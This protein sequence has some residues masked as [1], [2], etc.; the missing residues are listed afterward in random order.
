M[1]FVNC[2]EDVIRANAYATLEFRNT[3][4]LAFR[5]LPAIISEHVAGKRALDFGCGTGRSTRLLRRLGLQAMGIDISEDMLRLARTTDPDGEYR[6]VPGDNLNQFASGVFDL[7]L[8]AFTFDN[9]PQ[10]RKLKIF[11]DLRRLLARAGII[12][13]IVSSPEI[14]THEWASFSTKDFPENREARSGDVVRIVVTDHPD[15]RPVE[16]VVCADESYRNIYQQ[17][18][19]KVIQTF[20][21]LA[22]GDEDYSWVNETT[23]APWVIYVLSSAES[24]G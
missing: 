22:K 1:G 5:D 24:A 23:I 16:D 6:I 11:G 2:Y 12:V 19:L 13:S 7:I 17:A 9:I 8:S 14:Y 21:P 18:G 10:A 20:A 4:Y 15:R 3:Y